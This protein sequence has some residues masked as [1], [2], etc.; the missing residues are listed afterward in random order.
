MATPRSVAVHDTTVWSSSQENA[1][2]TGV[3]CGIR[4][5]SIGDVIEIVGAIGSVTP[6]SSSAAPWSRPVPTPLVWLPVE[7]QPGTPTAATLYPVP[8]MSPRPATLQPA[9]SPQR[10]PPPPINSWPLAVSVPSETFDGVLVP[11]TT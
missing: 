6:L 5:P 4:A 2:A 8:L 9:W 7:S 11:Y 10:Q 3:P 1:S